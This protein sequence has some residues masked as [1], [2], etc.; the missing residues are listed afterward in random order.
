MQCAVGFEMPNYQQCAS[1]SSKCTRVSGDSLNESIIYIE[2]LHVTRLRLGKIQQDPATN[3]TCPD[4]RSHPGEWTWQ[5]GLPGEFKVFL[6]AKH[7]I[8]NSTTVRTSASNQLLHLTLIF[9]KIGV[10]S[11]TACWLQQCKLF[12]ALCDGSMLQIQCK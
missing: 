2:D 3:Q 4:P 5:S 12:T 1:K 9:F 8:Y 11:S 10:R 6:H 7:V